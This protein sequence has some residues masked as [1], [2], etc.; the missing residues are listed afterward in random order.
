MLF[1]DVSVLDENFAV[2]PHQ[3]V[4]V[5]DGVIAHVG[6]KDPRAAAMMPG[7]LA[8]EPCEMDT[9]GEGGS[10]AAPSPGAAPATPDFG[11][12][13]D[14]A[15]RLL[16]PALYNTHAHSP[17]VLLRG[18]AEN[19]PLDRWL[20]EKC[21]PFE[22][23]MTGDDCYWGTLLACAEMAR[24][25]VVSFTDMYYNAE[26]SAQAV[27]ESGIK[28]NLGS[29]PVLLGDTPLAERAEYGETLAMI[30]HW[31]GAGDGRIRIDCALHSEYLT[32]EPVVRDVVAF[33]KE[34]GL[35]LHIHLSE[36]AKEVEECRGRHNGL[37]PVAYFDGVGLFEVPTTAAHCVWVDE[38]DMDIL[39]AR[40]VFV[41]NNPA[42]NLKLGSGFAPIPRMFEKGINVC[43][44]SDGMASNNNHNLF[45]DLYLQA[46]VYKGASLDPTAVTP[47]QALR[48]ATRTGALSQGRADC[49]LV[50]EGMRADLCLLDITGPSWCPATDLAYNLVYAG[51]GADVVLTLCDGRVV[52]AQGAFPTVDVERAK[53][54]CAARTKRILS[55][56]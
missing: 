24:F 33:A 11:E 45:H 25:G 42:S 30:E 52:Y 44:G 47:Q 50:R 22:A 43:L 40:G 1:A 34:C 37:S 10:P 49:G 51:N 13:I 53:A 4:G 26:R 3:W 56:L 15:G 28:A 18:Y 36:T 46:M 48:A 27:L 17:M 19:L 54:E 6:D 39:A 29:A 32:T 16:M 7:G 31:H 23:K 55:E 35:R 8:A 20:N 21:F 38:A 9:P 14:G 5:R 12:V 41:A 2:K